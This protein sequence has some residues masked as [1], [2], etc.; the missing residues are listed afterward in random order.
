MSTTDES[1]KRKLNNES[2]EESDVSDDESPT[3]HPDFW[4][5]DVTI[6]SSDNWS[7]KVARYHL[8]AHRSA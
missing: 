3:P 4:Q 1:K 5:G 7:F 6:I 8:Q 2:D